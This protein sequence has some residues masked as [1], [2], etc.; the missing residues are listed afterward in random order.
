MLKLT[1]VHI[2]RY[3]KNPMILFMTLPFPLL[4]TFWS[5]S[6]GQNMGETVVNVAV[7]AQTLGEYEQKLIDELELNE[8]YVYVGEKSEALD[9]LKTNKL[10]GVLVLP[11]TFSTDIENGIKPQLEMIQTIDGPLTYLTKQEVDSLLN[12][13]LLVEN[14]TEAI[15]FVQTEFVQTKESDLFLVS[16]MSI[17][18]IYF[19]FVASST[20]AKDLTMLKNDRVLSR[21]ISTAHTNFEI[22][23]SLILAMTVLLGTLFT[24]VYYLILILTDTPLPIIWM[25]FALM[26]SMAFVC[27]AFSIFSCRLVKTASMVELIVIGYS[28]LNFI[29]AIFAS[30]TFMAGISNELLSNLA[31]LLPM[32]WAYDTASNHTLWP[33]IPLIILFGLIFLTAGSLNLHRFS[34]S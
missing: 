23:G 33:N 31:K 3:L 22:M 8:D 10:S 2:R 19:M 16:I 18:V 7:V 13:W 17:M 34:R 24:F 21:M 27:T 6:F 25:P 32:Y 20:L 11:D 28:L 26:F 14:E 12:E 4:I 5:M 29:V 30:N 15:N 9:Q 1:W